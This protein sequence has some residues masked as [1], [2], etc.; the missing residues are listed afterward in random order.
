MRSCLRLYL[1]DLLFSCCCGCLAAALGLQRLVKKVNGPLQAQQVWQVAMVLQA[2]PLLKQHARV[3][4][5]AVVELVKVQ[6]N[7][8]SLL[9]LCLTLEFY[10]RECRWSLMSSIVLVQQLTA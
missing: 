5:G 1:S 7:V 4:G 6:Q 2:Q 9:M 3:L 10:N 8:P